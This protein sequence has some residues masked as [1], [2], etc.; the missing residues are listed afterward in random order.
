MCIY[1]DY[2]VSN[3]CLYSLKYVYKI[4]KY[5][6]MRPNKLGVHIKCK[7]LERSKE[8]YEAFGF[9][10]IFAYGSDKHRAGFKDINTAPE[11]YDGIVYE[12][13]GALLEI[14]NGHIAVKPGVFCETVE[15][16]KISLMIDVESVENVKKV[17]QVKDYQ[18]AADIREFYWGTREIVLR[19]PDGVIVVFREK[20]V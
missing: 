9:S 19:D 13:E 6:K 10:P 1:K 20:I 14:A 16:S 5:T 8:F 7:D 3:I 18:I 4:I 17:A 11:K 15:S 12:V 2:Q